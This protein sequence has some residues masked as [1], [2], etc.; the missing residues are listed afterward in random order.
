[1]V[2][3]GQPV[4]PELMRHQL[5]AAVRTC[6]LLTVA[7]AAHAEVRV[8]DLD[9]RPVDP[10]AAA[11]GVRSVRRV[12][13]DFPRISLR[14]YLPAVFGE[15][16]HSADFTD[17][18]LAVFDRGF[19][20]IEAQLDE[21]PGLFDPLSA[22]AGGRSDFLGFIASWIGVTL[23][24]KLPLAER[25][26]FLKQAGELAKLRGTLPGLRRTL[27]AHL[28][29]APARATCLGDCAPCTTPSPPAFQPPDLVLEHF[30]LRRWLLLGSGRLG[31]AAVL[32]G[33]NIVNRSQLGG[34]SENGSARLGSSQLITTQD[35]FRDP[36]HVYAHRFSVFVP[37]WIGRSP[38]R[39]KSLERL[40]GSEKP[41]NTA[42]QLVYVEPRFRI[43]VQSMIGFD[44]VVGRYPQG[45]ELGAAPLG[46]GTILSGGPKGTPLLSVGR[47]ARVG[48]TTRLA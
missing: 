20:E 29:L 34:P 7:A 8:V 28:G 13:L 32:W 25:R 31:D 6:L 9:G 30:K 16:P 11:P 35:P 44:A 47:D 18:L 10:F 15:E 27:H 40:I 48:T 24:R 26:R 4:A 23:D 41:A 33:Q 3:L 36:F 45:V 1:M 21:L 19:R 43:G 14:R 22:P 2:A 5:R 39:R 37:G 46:K 17:R 12:V 38:E 42:H